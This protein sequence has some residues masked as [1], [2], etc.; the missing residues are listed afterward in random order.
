MNNFYRFIIIS[1]LLLSFGVINVNAESKK[2]YDEI[3]AKSTSDKE[4]SEFVKSDNGID[5]SLPSSNLPSEEANINGKGIY[6]I[7]ETK[8]LDFP[9]VYYRGSISNN[10]VI[11][12]DFCWQIIRT[13]ENGGIRVLYAGPQIDG[14]CN[15]TGDSLHIGKFSYGESNSLDYLRYAYLD[16]S[17]NV[18]DSVIKSAVDSWFETNMIEYTKYLE[19]EPYCND[20]TAGEI[21]AYKRRDDLSSGKPSYS[22]PKEY[23]FTTKKSNGNGLLKYPV[24]IISADDLTYAGLKLKT[25]SPESHENPSF[26]FIGVSYWSMTPYTQNKLMYPNTKKSINDNTITYKAGARPYITLKNSTI[27]YGGDGTGDSPYLTSMVK[28]YDIISSQEEVVLYDELA[29]ANQE[30]SFSVNEKDGFVLEK[31]VLK[32]MDGNELDYSFDIP[33]EK[34]TFLMPEKD[35]EVFAIFR[36]KKPMYKVF[37]NSEEIDLVSQDVEEGQNVEYKIIEKEDYD[38]K[39]VK[40]YN[41]SNNEEINVDIVENNGSYVF[42]MPGFDINIEA[43]YEYNPSFAI[44]KDDNV[45]L[46]IGNAKQGEEIVIEAV[47]DDGFKISEVVVINKNTGEETVIQYEDD[48]YVF[49]MPESDV[50]IRV[51]QE[52]VPTHIVSFEDEVVISKTEF[53]EGEIVVFSVKASS[54]NRVY[55]TDNEGN[56][57]DIEVKNDGNNNYSFNMGNKDVKIIVDIND[58]PYTDVVFDY[59][60]SDGFNVNVFV[61]TLLIIISTVGIFTISKIKTDKTE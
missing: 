53:M 10:F 58:F 50:E 27:V 39:N 14:K 6:M 37:V 9:I 23:S 38:Y 34:Y 47:P 42:V 41:K 51:V 32:D 4:S 56:I 18:V 59:I 54:I 1:F 25:N 45:V 11:V 55:L 5:F 36:E 17:N 22:C 2:L 21:N 20:L 29:E 52:K 57:I 16:S 61:S 8:N 46:D 28:S 13:T 26:A 35:V 12:G 33:K 30:V 15:N 3:K 24:A 31:I 49:I 60:S 19:D 44:D 48:K 7:D 40:V 43:I